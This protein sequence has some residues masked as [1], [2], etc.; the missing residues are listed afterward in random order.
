MR[1]VPEFSDAKIDRKKFILLLTS[2]ICGFNDQLASL[3]YDASSTI[4]SDVKGAIVLVHK[5]LVRH[6]L[7]AGS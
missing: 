4:S 6:T 2:Q 3:L 5:L 7:L 1:S